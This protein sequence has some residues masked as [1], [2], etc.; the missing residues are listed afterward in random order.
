M[1]KY[2][3]VAIRRITALFAFWFLL[4]LTACTTTGIPAQEA[5]PVIV[6]VPVPVPCEIEQVAKP[7]RPTVPKG[8]TGI[9]DLT[10]TALADRRVLEADTTRLRAANTTP[11]KELK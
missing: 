10:K 8:T 7:V 3:K 2:P 1:I 6:K 9:F 5:P 4:I 11:C